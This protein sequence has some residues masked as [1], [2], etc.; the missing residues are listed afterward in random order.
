[1]CKVGGAYPAGTCFSETFVHENGEP[2]HCSAPCGYKYIWGSENDKR[3]TPAFAED[4]LGSHH[5]RYVEKRY[6]RVANDA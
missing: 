2:Y 4:H 3:V 1:M 6:I 5:T